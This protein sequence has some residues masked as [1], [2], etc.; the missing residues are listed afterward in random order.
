[1]IQVS[2]VHIQVGSVFCVFFKTGYIQKRQI[3]RSKEMPLKTNIETSIILHRW[4][5][6]RTTR[7]HILNAGWHIWV[8]G[9][10]NYL[11]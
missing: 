3:E 1:V 6:M 11:V 5:K 10:L 4:N 7:T 9:C 2:I 8:N